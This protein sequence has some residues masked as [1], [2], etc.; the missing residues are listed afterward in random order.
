M[1]TQTIAEKFCI[2]NKRDFISN[3]PICKLT[4]GLFP[5]EVN[6]QNNKS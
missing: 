6:I 1:K 4:A 5:D 2:V 3:K